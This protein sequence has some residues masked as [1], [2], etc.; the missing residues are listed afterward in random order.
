VNRSQAAKVAAHTRWSK[1]T[2]R[3]AATSAGRSAFLAR[4]AAQVDPEMRLDPAERDKR[5]RNAMRAHMIALR[6][7]QP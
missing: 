4:F 5:A 1:E 2:D 6:A 3:S 7:K